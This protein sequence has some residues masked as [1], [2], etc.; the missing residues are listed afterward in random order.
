MLLVAGLAA[1]AF[2]VGFH[3]SGV[4]PAARRALVT[5]RSASAVMR[6]PA[7]HDDDKEVAVRQAGLSLLGSVFS[8]LLR[9]VLAFL[10]LLT[11]ILV[12]DLAGLVDAGAALAF[13][14]R[15]DVALVTAAAM[16][17]IWLVVRRL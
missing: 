9:S 11:P 1:T 8:I 14:A 16:T 5:A 6:N 10:A 15:W 7:L 17:A 13:L 12:A 4:V 3:L 2:L